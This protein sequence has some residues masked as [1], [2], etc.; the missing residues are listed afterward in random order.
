LLGRV[1]ARALYA[2]LFE[3]LSRVP[4][5]A[6]YTFLDPRASDFYP[7]WGRAAADTV[8]LLRA[9]TGRHPDDRILNELIGELSTRSQQFSALWA[10]HNVRWHTTGIKQFHHRVAGDLSLD[11]EGMELASDRGQTLIAFTAEPGSTSH[12]ALQFLAS[13]SAT[14][15]P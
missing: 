7:D 1:L 15:P 13:W 10:T 8:A 9:E 4:N 2:D 11:H 14:S 12:N 3:D 6:P 5:H